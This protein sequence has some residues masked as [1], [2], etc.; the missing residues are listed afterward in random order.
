MPP[1]PLG[2]DRDGALTHSRRRPDL[3]AAAA[4]P[5]PRQDGSG[6]LEIPE[7]SKVLRR[8][9]MPSAADEGPRRALVH[10]CAALAT[11]RHIERQLAARAH[12]PFPTHERLGGGVA[13]DV[14]RVHARLAT[15]ELS[16]PLEDM[17]HWLVASAGPSGGGGDGGDGGGGAADGVRYGLCLKAKSS[18]YGGVSYDDVARAL[19]RSGLS[20]DGRRAQRL[21]SDVASLAEKGVPGLTAPPMLRTKRLALSEF[22]ELELGAM[23]EQAKSAYRAAVR[24]RPATAA[25]TAAGDGGARRGRA[26]LVAMPRKLA[27]R[28]EEEHIELLDPSRSRSPNRRS[29]SPPPVPRTAATLAAAAQSVAELATGDPSLREKPLINAQSAP[30]LTGRITP[31]ALTAFEA[32]YHARTEGGGGASGGGGGGGGSGGG[33]GGGSEIPPPSRRPPRPP[34]PSTGGGSRAADPLQTVRLLRAQTEARFAAVRQERARLDLEH[35]RLDAIEFAHQSAKALS[36]SVTPLSSCH[37]PL[38]E[39]ATQPLRPATA[40]AGAR[41]NPSPWHSSPTC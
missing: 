36:R 18:K 29:A 14:L 10:A 15:G 21:A 40:S 23:R 33:G 34:R 20:A 24:R 31:R 16:L 2:L 32:L 1:P 26:P 3:T 5:A 38:D 9:G 41:R 19:E 39:W 8:G 25:A 12:Q 7:L 27:D 28:L 35:R 13:A 6:T 17:P 4:P 30:A 22:R 37:G 11:R